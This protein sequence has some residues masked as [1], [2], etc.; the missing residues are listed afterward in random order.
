MD[1]NGTRPP[2]VALTRSEAFDTLLDLRRTSGL[3]A[4]QDL[5]FYTRSV[6]LTL[7]ENERGA[8]DAWMSALTLPVAPELHLDYVISEDRPHAAFAYG[9]RPMSLAGP[10][11]PLLPGWEVVVSC[12]VRCRVDASEHWSGLV[13]PPSGHVAGE[14]LSL[15]GLTRVPCSCGWV[16]G[17]WS[18]ED[19]ARV[20]Q[21]GH[22][23]RREAAA[24]GVELYPVGRGL[25]VPDDGDGRRE[26]PADTVVAGALA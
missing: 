8:V 15:D 9:I 5:R 22:A 3:E 6:E 14:P 25:A 10:R 11:S 26:D 17:P 2:G 18:S 20:E 19:G 21:R 23:R 24:R 12:L 13:L 1:N 4:P 16:S 7:P